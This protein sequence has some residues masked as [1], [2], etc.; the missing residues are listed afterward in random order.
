VDFHV[1]KVPLQK[2]EVRGP[3]RLTRFSQLLVSESFRM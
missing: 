2:D 3:D 1:V